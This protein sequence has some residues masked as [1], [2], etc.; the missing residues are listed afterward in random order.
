MQSNSPFL[1]LYT[2]V[3]KIG[4]SHIAFIDVMCGFEPRRQYFFYCDINYYKW[5]NNLK[6]KILFWFL[7][8]NVNNYFCFLVFYFCKIYHEQLFQNTPYCNNL[9]QWVHHIFYKRFSFHCTDSP[10]IILG[11]LSR[12]FFLHIQKSP[13]KK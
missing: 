12:K 4:I 1:F 10:H 11:N 13:Y 9:F 5:Q 7:F 6:N 2:A 3:G 8:H